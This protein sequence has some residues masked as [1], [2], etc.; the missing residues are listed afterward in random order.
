MGSPEV[1]RP[2]LWQALLVKVAFCL[3]HLLCSSTASD[4]TRPKD[5]YVW[6]EIFFI[7]FGFIT[8][9][10]TSVCICKYVAYILF[11]FSRR[12]TKMGWRCKV[13][14]MPCWSARGVIT[15]RRRFLEHRLPGE[16]STFVSQCVCLCSTLRWFKFKVHYT[17]LHHHHH[18]LLFL[19]TKGRSWI[20]RHAKA[21]RSFH[22]RHGRRGQQLQRLCLL[23]RNLQQ[24]HLRSPGGKSGGCNQTKVSVLGRKEMK[25]RQTHWTFIDMFTRNVVEVFQSSWKTTV[26]LLS[27]GGMVEAHLCARTLTSC[28]CPVNTSNVLQHEAAWNTGDY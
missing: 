5:L 2:S 21:R 18:C 27:L 19:K 15:R 3:V 11:R 22:I 12:M 4:R 24:L 8:S 1:E 17:F 25:L 20:F 13:R 26:F 10:Y 23:Y 14:L 6:W 28:M 16:S 9:C 7:F